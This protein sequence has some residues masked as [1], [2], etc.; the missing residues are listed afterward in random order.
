MKA[1]TLLMGAF[2]MCIGFGLLTACDNCN[3]NKPETPEAPAKLDMTAPQVNVDK[4]TG[5]IF[6]D[7]FMMSDP[8][9]TVKVSEDFTTATIS[10]DGKEIQTVVDE[11]ELASEE[12]TVHFLDANFDGLTD[13]YIGTGMPRTANSL[14]VWNE[15]E[16]KFTSV[17]GSSLQGFTID[18]ANKCV[19]QGGSNSAAEF[20]VTRDLW[21]GNKLNTI[22]HLS[23]I[24]NPEEYADY[25]V[26]H[27]FTLRSS[28]GNVLCSTE[29]IDG[30]PEIWQR[31]IKA[32]GF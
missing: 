29:T 21:E 8:H 26:E 3:N 18:H 27:M 15:K 16:Q 22:E 4:E 5:L 17:E 31:Y 28:D 23:V 30:L 25:N 6:L 24:S 12:A 20:I 19:V 2:T 32:Y 14:L 10:Y 1:K 11:F 9:L 13:I 7:E